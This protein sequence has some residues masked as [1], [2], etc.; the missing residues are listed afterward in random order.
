MRESLFVLSSITFVSWLY[1]DWRLHK[2]QLHHTCLVSRCLNSPLLFY[3]P[4]L[5]HH[6]LCF[7]G[8]RQ[9]L[10]KK[11]KEK[12]IYLKSTCVAENECSR[13]TGSLR[14]E[15]TKK[16]LSLSLSLLFTESVCECVMPISSRFFIFMLKNKLLFFLS[17]YLS[18]SLS[19]YLFI[20][21]SYYLSI[22][23]P[24]NHT[25]F[26]PIFLT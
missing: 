25:I 13:F 22:T 1:H 10:T 17:F 3:K 24:F 15:A 14:Y 2:R 26:L 16:I 23:H 6:M 7:I 18:I 4:P 21:Q 19:F 11:M 9:K 5:C 12:N 8:S 20:D